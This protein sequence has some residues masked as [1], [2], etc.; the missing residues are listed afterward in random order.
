[1]FPVPYLSGLPRSSRVAFGHF[2]GAFDHRLGTTA[3]GQLGNKLT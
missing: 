1:M 2:V 3:P